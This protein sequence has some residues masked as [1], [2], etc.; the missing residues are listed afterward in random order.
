MPVGRNIKMD[1]IT[2]DDLLLESDFTRELEKQ[3]QQSKLNK[4]DP[5]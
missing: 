4:Y 2:I 5:S 1:N 3:I